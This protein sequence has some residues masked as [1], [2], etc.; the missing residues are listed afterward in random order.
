[1]SN[2]V[3]F[4]KCHNQSNNL[5]VLRIVL[6]LDKVVQDLDQHSLQKLYEQTF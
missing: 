3:I 1:M 6:L 4:T 5:K 2:G